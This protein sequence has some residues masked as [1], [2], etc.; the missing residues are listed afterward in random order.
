MAVN[1]DTGLTNGQGRTF[2]R[3]GCRKFQRVI[4]VAED[5][6]DEVAV[7]NILAGTPIPVG[8][9]ETLYFTTEVEGLPDPDSMAMISNTVHV[10]VTL[11]AEYDL[12]NSW[13]AEA[14]GECQYYYWAF[15][16]GFW[17]NHTSSSPSGHDAWKYTAYDP[18]DLLVDVGFILDELGSESPKGS[19]DTFNDKT[20]LDALRFKGGS[21]LTGALEIL[22]RAGVASLLNASFHETMHGGADP[23]FPLSS[24]EVIEAVNDAIAGAID[25]EDPYVMLELAGILDGY[26]N[27]YEYF[28]WTWEVP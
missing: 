5:L 21:G 6:Y 18:G 7:V 25:T 4:E 26:N 24:A 2:L 22:M 17:K 20:L 16:P 12:S 13:M 8:V 14:T 27:G 28:D 10:T 15:T 19:K 23:Y 11:A 9:G 3:K 1:E